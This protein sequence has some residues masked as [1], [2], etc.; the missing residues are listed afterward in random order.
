MMKNKILLEICLPAVEKSFDVRIPRQLKAA[1]A[2][3]MLAE[4]IK[5]QDVEYIP[6]AQSVLC[7]MES[8]RAFDANAFI[9]DLGLHNGSKVMMV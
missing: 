6:T 9:G 2:A 3:A 8:G 5:K 4:F 1:Q 7:D